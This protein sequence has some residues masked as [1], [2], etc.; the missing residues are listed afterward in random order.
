[1]NAKNAAKKVYL[2]KSKFGG[3]LIDGRRFKAG[4]IVVYFP[5]MSFEGKD[6]G[7]KK[8]KNIY[9]KPEDMHLYHDM[10]EARFELMKRHSMT[11]SEFMRCGRPR[12]FLRK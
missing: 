10:D 12:S 3:T 2:I 1:M 5:R 11:E 8:F 4:E 7:G 6:D 9:V